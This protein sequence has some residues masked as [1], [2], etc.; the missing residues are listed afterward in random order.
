VSIAQSAAPEPALLEFR[1]VWVM[2]GD[3]V[4]LQDLNLAIQAGEHVAILGP[5]GCGKSTLI[6]T[7]MRELYPL[8]RENPQLTLMG[9][10]T[11]NVWDLRSYLGMVSNDLTAACTRDV[12]GREVV[13]SGFFSSIGIWPH[14]HIT[15]E[16]E[17]KAASLL[18]LLEVPHLA[19]RMVSEL[20]SGEA[21]RIVIARALVHEP[22]ALLLDEPANSLD[23]FA[24]H[25]LREILR[26]LARAGVGI[27][28]VTHN[29]P[30]IIPEI[31]RVI[32]MKAGRIFADGPKEEILTSAR[33]TELFGLPVSLARQDGFY[34]IW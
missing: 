18:R 4:V 14:Q 9:R 32:L 5:N 3:K 16:M 13:L 6:K 24:T 8:A 25:E 21:R 11:W 31:E 30:D 10:D 29:L 34:A 15:P 26:K 2:R 17:E 12:T 1:R 7:V 33:L 27:L 23:I 28:L 19:D 20:S 22:R